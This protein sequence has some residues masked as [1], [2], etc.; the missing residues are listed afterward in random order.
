MKI[1][2]KAHVTCVKTVLEKKILPNFKP[3]W[4]IEIM[5]N[6]LDDVTATP[7]WMWGRPAPHYELEIKQQ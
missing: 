1:S 3:P 6:A 5:T 2:A 7:P 4:M